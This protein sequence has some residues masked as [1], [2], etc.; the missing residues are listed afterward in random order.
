MPALRY[1]WAA[2]NHCSV[3]QG[4]TDFYEGSQAL[5]QAL[6]D[7]FA[8]VVQV[9]DWDELSDQDR[10]RVSDPRG[11]GM[12]SDDGGAL[13]ERIEQAQHLFRQLLSQLS[14]GL[15]DYAVAVAS[16]LGAS[17]IR[18]SPRRVRQLTRNLLA[19][20]ALNEGQFDDASFRLT[21]QASIPHPAWGQ[22]PDEATI[23]SAHRTA[24]DTAF[25]Q[26]REKWL[27][28]FLLE[29][30]LPKRIKKLLNE[31]PDPDTGTMAVTRTLATEPPERQALF[32]FALY[33]MTIECEHSP[34]GREGINELGKV[35]SK[36]L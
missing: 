4:D 26:G 33:P 36:I 9:P 10:L 18:L 23:H 30:F 35:C 12:L 20:T 27:N 25:S 11:E 28:T 34:I 16:L 29:P 7:R 8:F 1:R 32:A 17:G 24:W 3:D 15:Q 19:I 14:P 22:A 5:D 31:A 21:L 6:A 2:M 13:Q